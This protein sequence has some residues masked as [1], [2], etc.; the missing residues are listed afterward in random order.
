MIRTIVTDI[1]VLR[2]PC[3]DVKESEIS[4]IIKDLEETLEIY[5]NGV[6]LAGNQIGINKKVAIVRYKGVNV[7]LINPKVISGDTEVLIREACLSFPDAEI[8][9]KRYN[10]IKILNN[11][12]EE[13]YSC[14]L[15]IMVQHEVDHLYG[16]T[17]FDR[18]YRR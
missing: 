14:D 7:N 12:K 17:M 13:E 5:E 4:D 18:I 10:R 16:L 6:G 9:T 1:K 3:Q 8:P 11:G 15:A 2:L